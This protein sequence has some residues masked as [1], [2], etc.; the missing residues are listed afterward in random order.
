MNDMKLRLSSVYGSMC[1]DARNEGSANQMKRKGFST[2]NKDLREI[3]QDILAE[4]QTIREV[5][6]D[7]Q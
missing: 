3:L 7:A 5:L 2:N 1:R 4:L 6:Q